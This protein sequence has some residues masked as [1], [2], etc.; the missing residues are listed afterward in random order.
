MFIQIKYSP[1]VELY[2]C[3]LFTI[4]YGEPKRKVGG[5]SE[6]MFS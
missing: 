6:G 1:S 2:G 5:K 4:A 3:R